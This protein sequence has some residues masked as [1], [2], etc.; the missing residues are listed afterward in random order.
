MIFVGKEVKEQKGQS[1]RWV[2][3]M[4]IKIIKNYGR[5]CITER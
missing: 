2:I 5:I 1:I 3:S 4:S